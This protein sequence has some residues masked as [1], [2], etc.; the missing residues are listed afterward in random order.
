MKGKHTI[1]VP[2]FFIVYADKKGKQH[3][4]VIEVKPKNQCTPPERNPKR[5]TKYYGIRKKNH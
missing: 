5:R 3:A 4:E 1:Y 2:D